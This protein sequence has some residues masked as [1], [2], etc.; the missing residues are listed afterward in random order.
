M[1]TGIHR[2]YRRSEKQG[3]DEFYGYNCQL[4]AHSYYPD[5]LWDNDKRVELKDNTLDVQYGKGTYSQDLIHSKALDF[6][7]RMG[8]AENRSACGILPSSL[9]PN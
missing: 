4:L 1:G 7:D 5:H 2:L 9:M 6:L 8:K 3:I